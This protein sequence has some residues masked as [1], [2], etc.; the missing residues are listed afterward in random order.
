MTFSG[1]HRSSSSWLRILTAG[2]ALCVPCT[3]ARAEVASSS[4]TSAGYSALAAEKSSFTLF[5]P[6]PPELRRAL[7]TDRPT[8]T[9]SPY[10]VDAGQVQIETG[11]YSYT[12]ERE[13]GV[14]RVEVDAFTLG[15][16]SAKVGLTNRLDL[17]LLFDS[18]TSVRTKNRRDRSRTVQRGFGDVTAR[19]KYNLRGNDGGTLAFALLPFLTFPTSEDDLG[20][21]GLEGGLIAPLALKLPGGLELGAMTQLDLRRDRGGHVENTNPCENR[22]FRS[23]NGHRRETIRGIPVECPAQRTSRR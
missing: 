20:T 7:S 9:D 23:Q 12:S 5:H 10:T 15:G 14:N 21:D 19:L 3:A 8:R 16:I 1:S 17:E 13:G 18:Y 2:A 22:F 6:T 11:L 4:A